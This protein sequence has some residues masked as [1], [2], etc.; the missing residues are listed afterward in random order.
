MMQPG[1]REFKEALDR[2]LT[3]EPDWHIGHD[4]ER[5]GRPLTEIREPAPFKCAKCG[6]IA[7]SMSD[8]LKHQN[9][10]QWAGTDTETLKYKVKR[11]LGDLPFGKDH[12]NLRMIGSARDTLSELEQELAKRRRG[13][14]RAQGWACRE[15]QPEEVT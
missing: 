1:S 6:Y 15:P 14:K 3:T 13:R 5:E 12:N 10:K 7:S 4:E 9:E 8:L 11:A 2:H